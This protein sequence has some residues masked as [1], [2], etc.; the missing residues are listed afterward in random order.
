MLLRLL[1]PRRALLRMKE[2]F[3]TGDTVTTVKT[4]ELTFGMP[5]Y[6]KGLLLDALTQL[7]ARDPKVEFRMLGAEQ[8]VYTA[9]WRAPS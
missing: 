7:K 9:S 3:N 2:N 1:G 5:T 4:K 6:A 8:T